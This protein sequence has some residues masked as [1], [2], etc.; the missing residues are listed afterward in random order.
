MDVHRNLRQGGFS[1][2]EHGTKVAHRHF[3]IMSDARFVVQPAG[4]VKARETG[5]RNVHA[6]VRGNV[7]AGIYGQIPSDQNFGDFD[8]ITYNP[9]NDD[10]F[11]NCS[12][13]EY[14]SPEHLFDLVILTRYDGK[15]R[16]YV[17]STH[18]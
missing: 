14:V 1:V 10:F 16:A 11:R 4:Q 5:Q 9:F 8:E 3:L 15:D 2:L 7:V 12:S 6:F 18:A 13:G 17:R